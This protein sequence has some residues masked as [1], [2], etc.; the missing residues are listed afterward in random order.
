MNPGRRPVPSRSRTRAIEDQSSVRKTPEEEMER[1][2][3]FGKVEQEVVVVV[4]GVRWLEGK[5]A[6]HSKQ[7][8]EKPSRGKALEWCMSKKN[9]QTH[10]DTHAYTRVHAQ[11]HTHRAGETPF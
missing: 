6:L 10:G 7:L 4:V 5:R 11:T 3:G 8:L 1:G 2:R 9:T